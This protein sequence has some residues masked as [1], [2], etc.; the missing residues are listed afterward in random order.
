MGE[1]KSSKKIRKLLV[2]FFFGT[3]KFRFLSDFFSLKKS[4]TI[5]NF[6]ISKIFRN[7]KILNFHWLFHRCF[8]GKKS[9]FLVPT[10]FSTKSFRI[11][12]DEK[13][14]DQI[15]FEHLFRSQILQR[16]Q[17]SHLENRAMSFRTTFRFLSKNNSFCLYYLT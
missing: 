7:F 8:F 1:K 14:I 12:F 11:F 6:E 17:K 4:M 15:F 16:F 13:K 10:F 2:E 9:K 5:Q 3:K